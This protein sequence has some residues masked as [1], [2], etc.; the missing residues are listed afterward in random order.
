MDEREVK[1]LR[2][3]FDSAAFPPTLRHGGLKFAVSAG[4]FEREKR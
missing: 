3:K 1:A 4:K 2:M